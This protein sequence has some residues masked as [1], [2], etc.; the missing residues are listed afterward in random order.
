MGAARTTDRTSHIARVLW[1]LLLLFVAPTAIAASL[2]VAPTS[3][4]IDAERNADGLTLSNSGAQSLYAQV[5]V[6]RWSQVDGEDR[7]EPTTDVAISPP[8]VELPP[9]GEQLVRVIR[10]ISPP[11]EMESS[12]RVIVDEIPTQDA[13]DDQRLRFVLRYSVPIFLS[14]LNL[15]V[16][17][18]LH[19]TLTREADE[20]FLEVR[21]EG[22]AHA[23]LAD[24][25]LVSGTNRH[26][27]APGLA[28][29]VLPGQQ[30]RWLLP[31]DLVLD[32]NGDFKARVNAE[33]VERTLA[34]V[35]TL[36]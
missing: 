18:V 17:P 2:Q 33:L 16:G 5:R 8:M 6:F 22:S 3:L 13:D 11:T 14:P 31:A 34:P 1:S 24:L 20:T 9:G 12:Y 28:G 7:L 15:S 35:A 10:L 36:R 27:I 25:V 30:R 4:F 19:T 29:Y 26:F 32:V 23:Q 21:N